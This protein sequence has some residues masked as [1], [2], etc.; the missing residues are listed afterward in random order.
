M[1]TQRKILVS[2][3]LSVQTEADVEG[4][5]GTLEEV[6]LTTPTYVK[7]QPDPGLRK[8]LGSN[9]EIFVNLDQVNQTWSS[10]EHPRKVFENYDDHSG[11]DPT[12]NAGIDDWDSGGHHFDNTLI[13]AGNGTNPDGVTLSAVSSDC[14]LLYLKNL[15]VEPGVNNLAVELGNDG[16]WA[17]EILKG[18]ALTLTPNAIACNDIRVRST[19]VSPITIQYLVARTD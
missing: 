10:N 8:S 2:H 16:V 11:I 7:Y 6:D 15:G 4:N 14:K 13:I 17:I 1:P 5:P 12:G 18:D 9:N 3:Y 19:T